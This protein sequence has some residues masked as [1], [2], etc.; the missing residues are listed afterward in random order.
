MNPDQ[1]LLG[2]YQ[3]EGIFMQ[4]LAKEMVPIIAPADGYVSFS[5][6]GW[7]DSLSPGPRPTISPLPIWRDWLNA[8][9]QGTGVGQ[10][11]PPPPKRLSSRS[12]TIP[13]GIWRSRAESAAGILYAGDTVSVRWNDE[14][15]AVTAE[16]VRTAEGTG[17][18][19]RPPAAG[20]FADPPPVRV[21]HGGSRR[22]RASRSPWEALYRENGRDYIRIDYNGQK[23]PRGGHGS[24]P[25]EDE[26]AVVSAVGDVEGLSP[27]VTVYTGD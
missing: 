5:L 20:G 8:Q 14:T 22:R 7:E 21:C 18:R 23:D 2:L 26:Y 19:S 6:D 24:R 4:K 27:G 10:Y 11:V 9:G 17:A 25:W 1:H 12:S 13:S 16:V 3:Q 15:E